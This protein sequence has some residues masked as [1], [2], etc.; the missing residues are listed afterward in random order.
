MK[1]T[2]INHINQNTI[3]QKNA[4]T[5]IMT[6]QIIVQGCRN[7]NF[8]ILQDIYDRNE[9]Y[10]NNYNEILKESIFKQFS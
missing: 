5:H 8:T 7:T 4:T 3:H 9:K 1:I 6:L 2:V 10:Y